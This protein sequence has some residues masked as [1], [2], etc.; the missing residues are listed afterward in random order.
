MLTDSQIKA[1]SP[2]Q[3]SSDLSAGADY[4][5]KL[6]HQAASIG[7]TVTANAIEFRHVGGLHVENWRK[8]RRRSKKVLAGI[9]TGGICFADLYLLEYFGQ[10]I[11]EF[12]FSVAARNG[13]KI[14]TV[15]TYGTD[16]R[17]QVPPAKVADVRL[18]SLQCLKLF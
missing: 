12:D 7:A 2:K 18:G 4:T 11:P 8:V 5:L 15:Q 17:N 3:N 6:L 13:Q 16:L 1:P 10:G 14:E 9:L